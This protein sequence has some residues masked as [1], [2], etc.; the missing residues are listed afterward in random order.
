[1]RFGKH[2]AQKEDGAQAANGAPYFAE[3]SITDSTSPS[4]YGDGVF[5]S[6]EP[7]SLDPFAFDSLGKFRFD[8]R[9]DPATF[10]NVDIPTNANF[11]SALQS[12]KMELHVYTNGQ[13]G[14]GFDFAVAQTSNVQVRVRHR[15]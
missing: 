13:V 5:F 3:L 4:T 9:V 15:P 12:S 7:R 11:M 8:I 14:T 10:T 2:Q 6:I 1:M